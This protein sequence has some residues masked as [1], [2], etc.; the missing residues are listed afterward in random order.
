MHDHGKVGRALL[1]DNA[2]LANYRRQARLGLLHAVL[3]KLCRL[4]RIG[5]EAERHCQRHRPVG[6]CLAAH[7]EHVLDAVDLLLDRRCHGLRDHLRIG[8]G[9]G[10]THHHG[11]RHDV[12][13]FRDRHGNERDQAGQEDH[14]RKHTGKNRPID[15]EL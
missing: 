9:V 12:R 14:D 2:E 1:G 11:G 6:G 3:H 7:V 4:V 15:E 8:A 5:A 10:R 13:I